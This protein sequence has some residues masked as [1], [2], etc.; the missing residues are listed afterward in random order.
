MFFSLF[1]VLGG[2]LSW[3]FYVKAE[4]LLMASIHA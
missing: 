4:F 3:K 2:N 1:L